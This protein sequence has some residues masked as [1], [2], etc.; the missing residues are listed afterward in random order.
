MNFSGV[1]FSD[2]DEVAAYD[3]MHGKFRDYARA[4]E[5]IISRLS[6]NSTSTVIDLG[7]GT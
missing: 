6:L 3:I 2:I 5:E 4:S 1:D 7:C